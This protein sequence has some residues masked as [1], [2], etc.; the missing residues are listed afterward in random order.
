MVQLTIAE[1]ESLRND[2]FGREMLAEFVGC[3]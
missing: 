1:D 3:A 2:T